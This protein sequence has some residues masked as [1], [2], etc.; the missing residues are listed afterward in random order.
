MAR[1]AGFTLGEL[2]AALHATLEGD[3]ARI[4]TGVA[5]LDAAGPDQISFLTDPRYAAAAKRSRAGAFLVGPDSSG[6]PSPMLR[7][8]APPRTLIVLLTPL[9]PAAPATPGVAPSAPVAHGA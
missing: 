1:A 8:R 6:L 3:S 5:A 2:A 4:V 9:H 7:V